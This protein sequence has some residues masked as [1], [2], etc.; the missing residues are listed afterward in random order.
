MN[1]H[2]KTCGLIA[3]YAVVIFVAGCIPENSLEWSEDGSI[4]LLRFE[5]ALFLVD[6]KTGEL[7]EIAKTNV[8]L[9]PDISKD[10]NLIAYSEKVDFDSLSEGLKLLPPGQVKMIEYY[11]ELTKK[12]IIAAHGLANDRFPFPEEGLLLPEDYRNWAI[13]YLCENAGSELL[14]ILGEEGIEK[15]K[16]KAISYFQVVV[17]LRESPS[18]KRIVTRSVFKIM[19]TQ[20]SPDAKSVAY[21]MHTQE[22]QVS[23]AYQEYGLYIASLETDIKAMLVD[24]RVSIGY[25]WREDGK[26]IAYLNADSEHLQHDDLILG[27]L[28]EKLVVDT[29]GSLL[30]E[31]MQLPEEGSAGMHRC[32]G[33]TLELAGTVNYPWFKVEYGL[34]NRIF[35]SSFSL[36]LPVSKRDE[37]TCSLFCYDPVTA[38]VTDVLPSSVSSHTSQQVFSI[39]QFSLSPDRKN[40][41]LPIKNNRFVVYELGTGSMEIPIPEEEGFGEEE[42]PEL[43]PSWKGIDEISFLVS[44]NS[45]F[46]PKATEGQEKSARQEIVVLGRTDHKSWILSKNWPDEIT[47][48]S[49]DSQE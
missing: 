44:E 23:N 40:V 36:P 24:S 28:N 18:K 48:G 14:E 8:G 42:L 34:D 45:H 6:G 32:T 27:T 38:T 33:E 5:E 16:E 21:L 1:N 41:L 37:P 2:K 22:G 39:S 12:N 10:G 9:L 19:A 30:A 20:L 3:F 17:V 43:A 13:R 46:L 7:T 26:A 49:Q 29:T 4:G 47:S 25:D 11:A 35:F 31:P 15:G